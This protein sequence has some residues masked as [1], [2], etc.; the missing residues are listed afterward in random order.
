LYGPTDPAKCGPYGD[1]HEVILPVGWQ[2]LFGKQRR[3]DP[4]PIRSIAIDR[5]LEACDRMVAKTRAGI[6][7]AA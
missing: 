1:H 4:G 7:Q 5:V 2:E 6:R 3:N